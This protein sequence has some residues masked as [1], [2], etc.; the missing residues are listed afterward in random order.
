MLG[1]SRFSV[2]KKRKACSDVSLEWE[3]ENLENVLGSSL[4]RLLPAMLRELVGRKSPNRRFLGQV[5]LKTWQRPQEA[6]NP[7][8]KGDELECEK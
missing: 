2:T 7:R 6:T 8:T 4:N 1:C 3:G 5:S